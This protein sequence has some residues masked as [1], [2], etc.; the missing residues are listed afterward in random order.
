MFLGENVSTE[1]VSEEE[2]EQEEGKKEKEFGFGPGELD[3]VENVKSFLEHF[4]NV[5][6]CNFVKFLTHF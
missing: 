1:S 6:F 4:S 2:D 3:N 5:F